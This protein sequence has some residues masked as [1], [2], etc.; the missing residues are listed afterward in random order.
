MTLPS[1]MSHITL[2]VT[3]VP[4][5]RAKLRLQANVQSECLRAKPRN[6]DWEPQGQGQASQA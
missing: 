6:V 2:E 3:K 5:V 1:I 4:R